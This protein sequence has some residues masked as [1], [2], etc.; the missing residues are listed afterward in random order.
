[1]PVVGVIIG[2]LGRVSRIT[3]AIVPLRRCFAWLAQFKVGIL[4][5]LRRSCAPP[6]R[7]RA[8]KSKAN[9][10]YRGVIRFA[11]S[12]CSFSRGSRV[13]SSH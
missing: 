10:G 11:R 7:T 4:Y 2:D 12:K 13:V 6:A 1:M 5:W 3:S 8:S 9:T